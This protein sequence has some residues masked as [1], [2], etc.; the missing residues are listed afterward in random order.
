MKV[1]IIIW[2]ASAILTLLMFGCTLSTSLIVEEE[3]YN[4]RLVNRSG[5]RVKICWDE[6][7]YRYI[8]DGCVIYIPADCGDY[9]LEWEDDSPRKHTRPKQ[10]YTIEVKADI[11]I[12]F[13]E[14][15][16][17]GAIIIDL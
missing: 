12:I 13:R 1:R 5:E 11:E 6:G 4:V 9:E 17:T 2:V 8:D 10:V 7:S 3:N 14:D 16:D 15:P